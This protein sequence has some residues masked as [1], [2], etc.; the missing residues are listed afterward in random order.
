MRKEP[1]ALPSYHGWRGFVNGSC[2]QTRA[3]SKLVPGHVVRLF[4]RVLSTITTGETTARSTTRRASGVSIARWD[5]F[6]A[7]RSP[8]WH[9]WQRGEA[10]LS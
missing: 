10:A 7:L 1:M 3:F 4:P 6:V 8:A 2:A 5:V 9:A